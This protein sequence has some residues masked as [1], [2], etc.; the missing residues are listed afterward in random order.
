MYKSMRPSSLQAGTTLAVVAALGL[1][2]H[3][4]KAQTLLSYY[5][6]NGGTSGVATPASFVSANANGTL[7]FSGFTTNAG[8]TPAHEYLSGTVLNAQNGSVSGTSL[9]LVGGTGATAGGT[10]GNNGS[11]IVFTVDTT[12]YSS[13][14]VSYATQGSSTGFKNDQFAYNTGS[15]YTNFGSAYAP[16]LSFTASGTPP[17]YSP[18]SLQT[19][20]LTGVGGVDNNA[21]D[22]FRITFT[23]ATGSTGTNR[24][25]NLLITGTPLGTAPAAPEPSQVAGLVFFAL[26]LA[27]VIL[28]ARRKQQA[29]PAA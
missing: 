17:A 15:G 27:G 25:D 19:F 12:G 26:G 4:A 7:T 20:D 10:G 23:G 5:D 18:G 9:G 29:S 28:K 14:M 1:S 3:P 11:S 21:L 13:I 22:Q 16:P 6:F 2:A 24:I 8:A